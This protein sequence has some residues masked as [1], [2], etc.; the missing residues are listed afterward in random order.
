MASF[1]CVLFCLCALSL[2]VMMRFV[3]DLLRDVVC[4]VCVIL[5]G[6]FA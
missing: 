6:S 1:L 2:P 4:G 3:C 5:C